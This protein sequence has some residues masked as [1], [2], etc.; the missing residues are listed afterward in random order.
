MIFTSLSFFLPLF[1]DLLLLVNGRSVEGGREREHKNIRKVIRERARA[2]D[3]RQ[4]GGKARIH[5][6]KKASLA[7]KHQSVAQRRGMIRT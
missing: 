7:R 3:V 5:E 1:P 4:G 2:G 6:E